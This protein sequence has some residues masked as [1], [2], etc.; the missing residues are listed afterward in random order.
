MLFTLGLAPVVLAQS[1][2][3][4][5]DLCAREQNPTARLACFDRQVAAR[6]KSEPVSTSGHTGTTLSTTPAPAPVPAPVAATTGT[7]L[8]TN[9]DLGLDARQ[10]RKLHPERADAEKAAPT[11]FSAKVVKV[12][13]RRPLISAFEL[14]NGQIW[15]QTETVA[16]LWITP[17]ETVTIS[18]GVMGGFQLR[19]A[20]GHMTR[21]H[22]VK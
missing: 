13:A 21:V 14:D 20:D 7:T 9:G 5:F 1:P 6:H 3:D 4:A 19:S 16:G 11:S 2:P 17:Q 12:I 22:R 18:A 8:S 10:L 15:E